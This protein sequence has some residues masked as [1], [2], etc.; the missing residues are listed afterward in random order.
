MTPTSMNI[1]PKIK[2]KCI[3]KSLWSSILSIFEWCKKTWFFEAVQN[4]PKMWKN[5]PRIAQE[6][7]SWPRHFAEEW[8][9][10]DL[11]PWGGLARDWNRY[12]SMKQATR[13]KIQKQ[14]AWIMKPQETRNKETREQKKWSQHA[15][16]LVARR[17]YLLRLCCWLQAE[18]A[19]IMLTLTLLLLYLLT[20][21]TLCEYAKN[22]VFASVTPRILKLYQELSHKA[23]NIFPKFHRN[24]IDIS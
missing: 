10:W 8:I 12:R 4:V 18:V 21:L 2:Q 23:G 9:F 5:G 11:G 7:K 17:I 15:C 14:V 20:L 19:A 22:L 13:N 1:D 24:W 6:A 16:G 3:R